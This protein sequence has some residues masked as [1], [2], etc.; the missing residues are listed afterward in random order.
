MGDTMLMI[1]LNDF[2]GILAHSRP[3]LIGGLESGFRDYWMLS[4]LQNNK[5]PDYPPYFYVIFLQRV[6][7]ECPGRPLAAHAG[8]AQNSET[9]RKNSVCKDT[10]SL[11]TPFQS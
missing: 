5:F 2:H 1:K 4:G 3:W 8:F 9:Y 6:K 10:L 7:F 11:L